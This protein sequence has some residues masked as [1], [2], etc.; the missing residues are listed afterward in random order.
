MS[1]LD[2]WF[3]N[4]WLKRHATSPA[5]IRMQLESADRDLADA[6]KDISAA[7]RFAIAY[8][9]ALRFCSVALLASGYI[10]ERE[11]KHYRTIA[12]LPLIIGSSVSDLAGFLDRCRSKRHDVTYESAAAISE[13]ESGELIGGVR[14]L[15][16]R[17]RAWL[18]KE[19]PGL[20]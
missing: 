13:E 4:G 2:A 17:V 20:L 3:E 9:A 7:W 1:T 12:A 8:N 6:E 5:E 11:Q 14:E 10:A 15:R 16:G 19:H 18:E